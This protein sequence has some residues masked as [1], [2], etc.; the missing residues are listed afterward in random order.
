MIVTGS[1]SF[2][3]RLSLAPELKNHLALEEICNS[4]GDSTIDS[5]AGSIFEFTT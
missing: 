5:T 1:W 4:I 2:Y 3:G